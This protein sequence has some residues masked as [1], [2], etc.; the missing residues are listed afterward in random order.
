M[1]SQGAIDIGAA[2]REP[3]LATTPEQE[4]A[5]RQAANFAAVPG[6]FTLFSVVGVA[7]WGLPY[8]Y[9]FMVRDLGWTR[10]QVTSGNA[11]SQSYV[12]DRSRH[13]RWTV[14]IGGRVQR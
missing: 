13:F 12:G 9:D 7:L 2:G 10:A 5:D 8:Y 1:T 4:P 3:R 11:L 6:F 14:E